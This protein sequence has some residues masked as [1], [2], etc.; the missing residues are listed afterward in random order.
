MLLR[1]KKLS[2]RNHS[3]LISIIPFLQTK[4]NKT[5]LKAEQYC[6]S[7]RNIMDIRMTSNDITNGHMFSYP[8]YKCTFFPCTGTSRSGHAYL[9]YVYT[10]PQNKM[11]QGLLQLLKQIQVQDFCVK[12]N[13]F[14]QVRV[15]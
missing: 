3:V 12:C 9:K 15:Q 11:T 6:H 14:Q 5:K 4:Q 1:L 10:F 7:F 2:P 13:P 8:A